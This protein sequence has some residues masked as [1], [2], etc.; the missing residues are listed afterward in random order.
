MMDSPDRRCASDNT[1]SRWS[2]TPDTTPVSQVAQSPSRHEDGTS[3]R[4]RVRRARTAAICA[5]G[6]QQ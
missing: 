4:R 6:R 5:V 2:G 3:S 1:L